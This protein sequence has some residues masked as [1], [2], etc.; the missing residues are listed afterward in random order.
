MSV[1]MCACLRWL[2]QQAL[3]PSN[4]SAGLRMSLQVYVDSALVVN[5]DGLHGT[6]SVC[7]NAALVPGRHNIEV[8]GFKGSRSHVEMKLTYSG[9]DTGGLSVTVRSVGT[10]DPPGTCK[11]GGSVSQR[12]KRGESGRQEAP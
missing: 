12:T 9:P 3:M 7:K 6:K 11:V 5:N 1:H 2:G 10:R 4:V 8:E